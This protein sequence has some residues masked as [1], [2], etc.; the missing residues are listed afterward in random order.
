MLSNQ[1]ANLLQEFLHTGSRE[2]ESQTGRDKMT[3]ACRHVTKF[4]QT[5]R[6]RQKCGDGKCQKLLLKTGRRHHEDVQTCSTVSKHL[7]WQ[8]PETHSK[9]TA[10]AVADMITLDNRFQTVKNELMNFF[11]FLLNYLFLEKWQIL[12]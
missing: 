5:A 1:T 11:Y 12:T 8:A 9:H 7:K 10:V 4:G 6:A 3:A 2:R